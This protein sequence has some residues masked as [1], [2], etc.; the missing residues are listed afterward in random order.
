V[1]FAAAAT[2]FPPQ[3][4][5]V[6]AYLRDTC[7]G[8]G[9]GCTPST[10]L[11][12]TII[13]VQDVAVSADGRYVAMT[14]NVTTNAGPLVKEVSVADTCTGAA[15]G[16]VPTTTQVSATMNNA[17]PN[18]DSG[19]ESISADGRFVAYF[20]ADSQQVAGDTNSA[21]DVFVRDTCAGGGAGCAPRTLRI[22]VDHSGTQSNGDSGTDTISGLDGVSIARNGQAAAFLSKA[23][24]LVSPA[25]NGLDNIF[26]A[27]TGLRQPGLALTL[28]ALSPTSATHGGGDL[29]LT[30][31]GTGFLPGAVAQWSGAPRDTV[32][33]NATK[34]EVFIPAA[35]IANAG[36]SQITVVNP[37]PGSGTGTLTFTI[38]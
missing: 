35:D 21:N 5:S 25:S 15:A 22:S 6:H 32:Y 31:T 13:D 8:A 9:A 37:A 10:I 4:G 11:A 24:N 33:V 16:C 28:T 19:D 38:N 23:T 12:S 34:L 20:S 27:D 18:G 17:V 2:N 26:L 1:A 36:S 3:T 14:S 29:V 30:I 7:A